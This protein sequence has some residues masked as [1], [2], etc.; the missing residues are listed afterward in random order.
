MKNGQCQLNEKSVMPA[1]QLGVALCGDRADRSVRSRE[2]ERNI[3][4]PAA[5]QAHKLRCLSPAL[6]LSVHIQKMGRPL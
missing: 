6:S 4:F 2:H 3:G 5:P 1:G